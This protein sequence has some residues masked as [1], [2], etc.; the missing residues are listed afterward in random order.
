MHIRKQVRNRIT[1]AIEG[2]TSFN[3]KVFENRT[4]ELNKSE[5]P[6]AL[7]FSGPETIE[8]ATKAPKTIGIQ[9]RK[10]QVEVYI[11]ARDAENIGNAIDDL[12]SEVEEKI[13]NDLPLREISTEISILEA[14]P[15]IDSDSD[16]PVGAIRMTFQV[17]V[18]T[19]K[20]TPDKAINH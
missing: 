16:L 20:G 1:A 3:G 17:I 14:I 2:I 13:F 4:Y 5:L 10:I 15:Y 11:F 6:A 9:K 12:S 7:I 19:R 18:F 8:D